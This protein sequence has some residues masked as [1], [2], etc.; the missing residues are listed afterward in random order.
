MMVYPI[1]YGGHNQ[2]NYRCH[3]AIDSKHNVTIDLLQLLIKLQR[4]M[5]ITTF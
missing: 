5:E 3:L 4:E 2:R 1:T